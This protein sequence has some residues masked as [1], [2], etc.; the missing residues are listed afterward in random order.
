M[1][2]PFR[3]CIQRTQDLRWYALPRPQFHGQRCALAK[4]EGRTNTLGKTCFVG[5]DTHGI[6]DKSHKLNQIACTTPDRCTRSQMYAIYAI[7]VAVSRVAV[8][9]LTGKTRVPMPAEVQL[10][11]RG[12]LS[13][14]KVDVIR[15]CRMTSHTYSA[16]HA[17]LWLF[18]IRS[19][20][21]VVVVG[22]RCA[23]A[24]M[25]WQSRHTR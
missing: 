1:R 16:T 5:L 21:R 25:N 18:G 3:C 23:P 22:S 9:S 17:L 20:L 10:V 6:K 14:I 7:P 19:V 4:H 2:T 8:P 24:P 12:A 13:M 11:S 15:Q